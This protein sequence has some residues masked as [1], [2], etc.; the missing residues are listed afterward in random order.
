MKKM[1][2]QFIDVEYIADK[3]ILKS[4]WKSTTEHANWEDV[5]ESF[6]IFLDGVKNQKPKYLMVDE[7][8]MARPYSPDE[9]KWVDANSATVV[10]NSAVEK[11]AI[12]ISSDGFV[13]LS[14]ESMMVEEEVS[15][16]LNTQF[17]DNTDAA[18]IWFAK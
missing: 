3:Q 2:N 15:K 18:E 10:A 8:K 16:G 13:E 14:T 7:R 11:I 1:S 4:I 12:I 5:K 6:G 9:Q 17:F